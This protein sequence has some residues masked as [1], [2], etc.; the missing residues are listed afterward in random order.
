MNGAS[1]GRACNLTGSSKEPQTQ[2]FRHKTFPA[3]E[4][5]HDVPT[6]T[7]KILLASPSTRVMQSHKSK[8][9]YERFLCQPE[10]S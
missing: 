8:N 1:S 3:P 2:G 7:R 5:C 9:S 4:V 10:A 6:E